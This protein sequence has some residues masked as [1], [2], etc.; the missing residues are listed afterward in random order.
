MLIDFRLRGRKREQRERNIDWLS[1]IHTLTGVQPHNLALC[2]NPES[3]LRPSGVWDDTP[4][5]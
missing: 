1:L 3:N 2:P 5:H 4:T